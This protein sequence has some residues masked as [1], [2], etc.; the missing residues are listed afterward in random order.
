MDFLRYE[1][2]RLIDYGHFGRLKRP[3]I[4]QGGDGKKSAGLLEIF[5]DKSANALV[6]SGKVKSRKAGQNAVI[7]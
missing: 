2:D 7:S 5:L 4:G 3:R 1:G 6:E